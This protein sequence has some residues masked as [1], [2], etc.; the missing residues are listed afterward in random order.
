MTTGKRLVK[1]VDKGITVGYIESMKTA[2][3]LPDDLFKRVNAFAKQ[4]HFS[5]SEVFVKATEELLERKASRDIIEALN[6]V[7]SEPETQE[8]IEARKFITRLSLRTLRQ[9]D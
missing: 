1:Y 4:H 3:S 7:Y 2:I 6:K 9:K 8:D 5:R